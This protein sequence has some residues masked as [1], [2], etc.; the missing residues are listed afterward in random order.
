MSRKELVSAVVLTLNE[1]KNI[2]SCLGN[3]MW[4]DEIVVVDSFSQDRTVEIAKR[5]TDRVTQRTFTNFGDQWSFA[6]SMCTNDWILIV[7]AD[8]VITPA[9]SNEIR[10]ILEK[11]ELNGYYISTAAHMLGGWL[12][13]GAQYP[14]YHIKLFRKSH[15]HWEGTAHE[16]VILDGPYGFLRNPTLHY[17]CPDVNSF[18]GKTIFYSDVWLSGLKEKPAQTP[19]SLFLSP[20][21]V[22][23]WSYFKHGGF[24]D[25]DRGFV[26]SLLLL[27]NEAV[28]ATKVWEKFYM[29]P[30]PLYAPKYRLTFRVRLIR[31]KS[32]LKTKISSRWG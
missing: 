9:L 15:G 17:T 29:K 14:D 30:S 2:E 18:V 24:L 21:R 27:V 20:F 23:I 12:R 5:F 22:F 31:L 13:H 4:A 16:K 19:L 6:A 3:L 25:G 32:K 26:L 1:E 28:F 7:G 10:A 8:E 11:E